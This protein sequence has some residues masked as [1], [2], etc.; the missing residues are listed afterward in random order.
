MPDFSDVLLDPGLT[1][2]FPVSAF[3]AQLPPVGYPEFLSTGTDTASP[4]ISK[5]M[6]PQSIINH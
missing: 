3:N 6:Y 1:D 4:Y 5:E 2:N